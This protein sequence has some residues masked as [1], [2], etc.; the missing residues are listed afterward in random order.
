MPKLSIWERQERDEKFKEGLIRCAECKL[1][2]PK[3]KFSETSTEP[4]NYGYRYYCKIC[5]M[6]RGYYKD[7]ANMKRAYTP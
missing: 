7:K 2:L 4:S 1:F 6:Q 5:D 3:D